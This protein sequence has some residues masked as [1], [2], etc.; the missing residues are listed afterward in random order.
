[1]EARFQPPSAIAPPRSPLRNR[2]IRD[3]PIRDRPIRNRYTLGSG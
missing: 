2:P 3:R 1:M